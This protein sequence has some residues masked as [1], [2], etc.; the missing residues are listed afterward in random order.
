MLRDKG[1]PT[2][3]T[4]PKSL[5]KHTEEGV[6]YLPEDLDWSECSQYVVDH[7]MNQPSGDICIEGI[8]TV[9]ALRKWLIQYGTLPSDFIVVY[10]DT[11][12]GDLLDG[13]KRMGTGVETI[14]ND[15]KDLI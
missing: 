4:D 1:I 13:Q 15:I 6:T 5:V 7:W 9:R 2:Y 8:A 10:K 12:Y 14:W 3:C 11:Q